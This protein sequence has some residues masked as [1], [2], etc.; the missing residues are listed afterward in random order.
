MLML[1]SAA[2][3]HWSFWFSLPQECAQRCDEKYLPNFLKFTC[4]QR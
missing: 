4:P 2:L 3:A 1:C